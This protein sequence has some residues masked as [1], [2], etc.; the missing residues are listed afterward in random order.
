MSAPTNVDRDVS[1]ILDGR[2]VI[3]YRVHR[4]DGTS[5]TVLPRQSGA[6]WAVFS[7]ASTVKV[8]TPSLGYAGSWRQDLDEAIEWA[9]WDGIAS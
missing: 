4:P 5:R 9:H 1:K 8:R 6:G 2:K 3:G 7:G